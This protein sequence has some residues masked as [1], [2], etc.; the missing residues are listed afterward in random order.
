[1]FYFHFSCV[2]PRVYP[3]MLE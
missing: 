2:F 3:I 1:M